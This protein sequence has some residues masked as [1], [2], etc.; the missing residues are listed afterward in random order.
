MGVFREGARAAVPHD[1]VRIDTDGVL[2]R[3]G[4]GKPTPRPQSYAGRGR[5]SFQPDE[6]RR[7]INNEIRWHVRES[8][9]ERLCRATASAA[10]PV[11]R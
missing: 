1:L 2:D 3:E 6:L 5:I 8:A 10:R 4:F 9:P 7:P 11:G